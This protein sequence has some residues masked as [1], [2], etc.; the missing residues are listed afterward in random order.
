MIYNGGVDSLRAFF[1]SGFNRDLR[2][3]DLK[4]QIKNKFK[5]CG[6]L[7]KIIL[8]KEQGNLLGYV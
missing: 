2:E 3:D 5:A 8:P 6:A 7:K 1:I 4:R